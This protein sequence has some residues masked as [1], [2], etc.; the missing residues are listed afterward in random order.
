[1]HPIFDPSKLNDDE[2][3]SRI[4]QANNY[5]YM[6]SQLGHDS[7]VDSIRETIAILEAERRNRM[8]VQIAAEQLK[9]HPTALNPVTLGELDTT[10]KPVFHDDDER[11][12]VSKIRRRRI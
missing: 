9:K 1:M 7:A 6:Q 4:G 2:L 11:K 12:R 5:L 8:Q 3:M 10:P